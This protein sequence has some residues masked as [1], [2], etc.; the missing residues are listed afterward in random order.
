M[1]KILI[2]AF[3]C[4]FIFSALS[5]CAFAEV[6]QAD[7]DGTYAE[8][9]DTAPKDEATDTYENPTE[10]V[11]DAVMQNS[12]KL[13]S[14][15]SFIGSLFII[16]IYK[17]GLLPLLKGGAGAIAKGVAS[18][19]EEA[20]KQSDE[21]SS[22]SALLTARLAAGENAVDRIEKSV[23][24]LEERCARAISEGKDS[25]AIFSA[26]SVQSELL[27]EILLASSL[28]SYE[29][30]RVSEKISSIRS[31]LKDGEADGDEIH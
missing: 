18:L 31:L 29:K 27:Y 17:R 16:F 23:G 24:V 5:L 25:R 30:E 7:A 13:L 8:N 21:A 1:K 22:L 26:L 3:I 19:E 28:P 12:D 14:A 6:T 10:A 9:A 20:K 4:A 11:F 15:L 2:I